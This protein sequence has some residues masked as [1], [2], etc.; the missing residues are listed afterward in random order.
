MLTS[1]EK[2]R[3]SSVQAP[4]L[5]DLGLNISFGSGFAPELWIQLWVWV[6]GGLVLVKPKFEQKTELSKFENTGGILAILWNEE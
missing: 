3:F 2:V 1:G 4:I 6:R 5:L